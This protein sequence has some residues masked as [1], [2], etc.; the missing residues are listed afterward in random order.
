MG[1]MAKATNGKTKVDYIH[2]STAKAHRINARE[3][4]GTIATI[5]QAVPQAGFWRKLDRTDDEAVLNRREVRH[6]LACTR[7]ETWLRL[8]GKDLTPEER[9]LAIIFGREKVGH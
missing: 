7:N 4:L 2:I 6:L 1:G 5:L 3:W 8:H 9:L